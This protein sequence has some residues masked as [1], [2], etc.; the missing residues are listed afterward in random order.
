MSFM[1][2]E[3]GAEIY[4]KDWGAGRPVLF[5]HG[6]PLDA[7]AWDAQMLFLLQQGYRV[8]AHDRRGHGRSSQPGS[9]NDMDTFA[10]DLLALVELLDLSEVTLV[11]HGAGGGEVTRYVGRHGTRRI[12]KVVLI[13]AAP[14]HLLKTEANPLGVALEVFQAA[15]TAISRNR[16]KY[17]KELAVA[18]FGFNRAGARPL[19]DLIEWFVGVSMLGG[20]HPQYESIKAFSET[21]FTEDLRKF[22]VPTLFLHGDDDQIVPF[23]AST[24][25]SRQL[26]RNAV[27]KVYAGG[28]H[29][30]C[31]TH[32]EQVSSDLLAFLED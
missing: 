25:I 22:N 24:A 5:S 10:D 13:G 28:S 31:S 3:D 8:I 30:I 11:G 7:D 32:P 20:A 9:G 27:L 16:L 18:F 19:P 26:T 12:T 2:A 6:W 23:G 21:D 14:P 4:Y 29:G 1:T 15:R 17:F